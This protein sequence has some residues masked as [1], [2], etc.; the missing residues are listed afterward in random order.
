MISQIEIF[1]AVKSRYGI[2]DRNLAELLKCSKARV[3]LLKTGKADGK[4]DDRDTLKIKS[5][6]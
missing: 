3:E 4:T 6:E 5:A 1:M 2:T